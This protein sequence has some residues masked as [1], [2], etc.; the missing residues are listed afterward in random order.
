MEGWV[1]AVGAWASCKTLP[2]GLKCTGDV[3]IVSRVGRKDT[4][5]FLFIFSFV[6]L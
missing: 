1:S 3:F 4:D 6:E 5:P 2:L